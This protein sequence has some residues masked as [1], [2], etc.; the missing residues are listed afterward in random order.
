MAI[1]SA[2]LAGYTLAMRSICAEG[3]ECTVGLSYHTEQCSPTQRVPWDDHGMTMELAVLTPSLRTGTIL[4]KTN[5]PGPKLS[6]GFLQWFKS[7]S[8]QVAMLQNPLWC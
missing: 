4:K 8:D 7:T 1:I 2:G 3:P 5:Y 6:Q